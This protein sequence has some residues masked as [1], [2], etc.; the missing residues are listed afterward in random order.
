MVSSIIQDST[1]KAFNSF[2]GDTTKLNK[3]IQY[4]WLLDK[5]KDEVELLISVGMLGYR[6]SNYKFVEYPDI[7][8]DNSFNYVL[9]NVIQN[10][11]KKVELRKYLATLPKL[12]V[13]CISI[14][15]TNKFYSNKV[16]DIAIE[17]GT[18]TYTRQL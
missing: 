1:V 3:K 2:A 9:S 7:E 17:R 18:S 6:I 10:Y 12:Y 15:F 5:C 14:L 11:D 13:D 16:E 8:P 4:K